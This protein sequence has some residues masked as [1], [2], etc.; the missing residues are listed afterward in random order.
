MHPLLLLQRLLGVFQFLLT[1]RMAR[2]LLVVGFFRDGHLFV[3]MA[4]GGGRR[5][6]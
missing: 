6:C 1:D 3:E 4:T 2:L 5:W